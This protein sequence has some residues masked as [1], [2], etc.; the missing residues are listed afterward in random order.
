[1][2]YDGSKD[3]TVWYI[4]E[5]D[6]EVDVYIGNGRGGD[7]GGLFEETGVSVRDGV[8]WRL[9]DRWLTEELFSK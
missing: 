9:F 1:M 5:E 8:R 2:E 7:D 3:E 6:E 4:W